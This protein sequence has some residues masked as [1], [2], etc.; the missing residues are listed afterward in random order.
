MSLTMQEVP[1]QGAPVPMSEAEW[2]ARAQRADC[3]RVFDQPGWTETIFNHI[4]TLRVPGPQ[5]ALLASDQRLRP[6]VPRGHGLERG[7]G[8]HRSTARNS[9]A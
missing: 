2:Q 4:T 9:A 5:R 1:R 3:Y 8:G 7:G 6:D